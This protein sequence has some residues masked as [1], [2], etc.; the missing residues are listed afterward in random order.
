MRELHDPV[1]AAENQS[2]PQ[3]AATA[4]VRLD[5]RGRITLDA[6]AATL[7]RQEEMIAQIDRESATRKFKGITQKMGSGSACSFRCTIFTAARICRPSR[8]STARC[9][10]A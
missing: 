4:Q 5:E 1:P 8:S 9:M 6:D 2:E 10:S 3:N 7:A